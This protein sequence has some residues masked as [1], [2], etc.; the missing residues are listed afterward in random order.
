M[1]LRG[2]AA[3]LEFFWGKKE[4]FSGK[5]NQ[6]IFGQNH[7]IFVQAME[8]IFGQETSVPLNETRP[9]RLWI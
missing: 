6:V 9:V 5:K 7:L 3:P 4:Q 2:A 1:G 8:K